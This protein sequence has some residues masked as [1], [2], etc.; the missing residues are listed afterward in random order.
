MRAAVTGS[1]WNRRAGSGRQLGM[2]MT[3]RTFSSCVWACAAWAKAPEGEP[4]AVEREV[5][6]A[7][8]RERKR[9]GLAALAWSE[10]VAGVARGHSEEMARGRYFGHED[11][12]S[13]RVSERLSGAGVR[14]RAC[15]ENLYWQPGGAGFVEK[16]LAGWMQ[17][18]GHRANLLGRAY[19]ELGAGIAVDERGRW[20]ATLVVVG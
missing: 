20:V 8:N 1:A 11:L 12:Q 6:A 18:G 10:R 19:R 16:A 2:G 7:I 13:R 15:G 14:F 3:R 5:A 17:S 9:E 4:R